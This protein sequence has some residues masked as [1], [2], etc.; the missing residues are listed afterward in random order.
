MNPSTVIKQEPVRA[1]SPTPTDVTTVIK[2]TS[3]FGTPIRPSH[4]SP[5]SVRP[6]SALM[7]PDEQMSTVGGEGIPQSPEDDIVS[8]VLVTRGNGGSGPLLRA[9][10]VNDWRHNTNSVLDRL[11]YILRHEDSFQDVIFQV[12]GKNGG[13][14]KQFKAHKLILRIAS[15]AFDR[16]FKNSDVRAS[17][18]T[19]KY[20]TVLPV[21]DMDPKIFQILL[22]YIYTDEIDKTALTQQDFVELYLAAQKFELNS[23]YLKV[24]E[25]FR[26]GIANEVL[27]RLFNVVTSYND[28]DLTD[29]CLNNIAR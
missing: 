11:K 26:R 20:D 10:D 3:S 14:G 22:N 8:N 2:P 15:P 13:G 4:I 12:E 24:V 17:S 19:F 28:P 23:L 5:I 1:P 18:P 16:M 25:E 21:T 27:L 7:D 9:E 6:L 29:L